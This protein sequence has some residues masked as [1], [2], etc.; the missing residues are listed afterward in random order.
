MPIWNLW[1]VLAA[2]CFVVCCAQDRPLGA[3][4]TAPPQVLSLSISPTVLDVRTEAKMLEAAVHVT[5]DFSGTSK[6]EIEVAGRQGSDQTSLMRAAVFRTGSRNNGYWKLSKLIQPLAPNGTWTVK[7]LRVTDLA[8]NILEYS[9]AEINQ[10]TQAYVEVFSQLCFTS[11]WLCEDTENDPAAHAELTGYWQLNAA[12]RN[13]GT[14]V[15]RKWTSGGYNAAATENV[16]TLQELVNQ[17][18]ERDRRQNWLY[19]YYRRRW[20]KESNSFVLF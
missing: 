18:D 17:D 20:E 5:D 4:D 3:H 1:F 8:G 19:N 11:P 9:T 7:R 15:K 10:I 14:G 16:R 2:M 6:V 13:Y 12:G